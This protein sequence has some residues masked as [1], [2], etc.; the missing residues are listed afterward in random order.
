[1]SVKAKDIAEKLGVSTTTISLVLNNKPGVGDKTRERVLKEI[2]AMGFETNIK[3]KPAT[4]LKN[5]RFILFKGHGL[6]VGNTPFFSKLIESIECEARANGY[7]V[8]ISYLNKET[9]TREY[10]K[11]FEEDENTAGILLLATEMNAEDIQT[12]KESECPLLALDNCFDDS[13]IDYVQIDNIQGVSKAVNYL[14]GCGHKEIGYLHSSAD[15]YNF[16]QRY[17]GFKMA[18]VDNKLA[19]N[20]SNVIS[21]EPTIE[22]SYR[23]MKQYL[24]ENNRPPKALFADN[25]I[26]AMGASRALMES[27]YILPDDVSIVGFDDMPYCVMIRPQLTSVQVNNDG[28]GAVAVRRLADNISGKTQETVKIL[29]RTSLVIRNSVKEIIS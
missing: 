9:N 27:G 3:L 25:D 28:L 11:Q 29:I 7:N 4:S 21:L 19:L 22:G 16:E 15:I 24:E 17:L 14:S 6:V 26:L 18:L 5:I 2:E 12:F 20:P 23:D 1:M 13:L 8:I 10:V